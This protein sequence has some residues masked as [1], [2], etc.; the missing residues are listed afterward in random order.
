MTSEQE[1]DTINSIDRP[2]IIALMNAVEDVIDE[3]AP[4]KMTPV[5]VYGVLHFI[6]AKYLPKE[7]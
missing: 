5:E 7:L 3:I 2:A 4:D 1:V 6:A